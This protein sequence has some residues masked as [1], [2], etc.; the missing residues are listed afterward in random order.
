MTSH[1]TVAAAVG[2]FVFITLGGLRVA[3]A[4]PPAPADVCSLL[5]TAQINT[6]LGVTVGAG[7]PAGSADCQW[8]PPGAGFGGKRVLLE[9]LGSMG[10]L[11]PVDRFNTVKTPVP[12]VVKTPVSGLGD[13]AV[14]VETG[15]VALYV[16]KGTVVFQIRV[17]G[18]PVEAGKAKEKALA[19]DVLA[20]L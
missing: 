10:R 12:K 8:S 15:G 6:V 17:A 5:T 4:A 7:T 18:F 13:D 1:A 3:H 20:K 19:Q 11:T 2:A 14:Y 9:V 16:K